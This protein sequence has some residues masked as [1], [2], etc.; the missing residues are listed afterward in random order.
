LTPGGPR[1]QFAPPPGPF[2]EDDSC[3]YAMATM[4]IKIHGG[5]ASARALRTVEAMRG[6]DH[7]AG[8]AFWFKVAHAIDAMTTAQDVEA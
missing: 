6:K 2:R 7:G 5:R 3:A 4:L 1:S 8:A